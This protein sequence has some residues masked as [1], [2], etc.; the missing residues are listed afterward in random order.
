MKARSY[1]TLLLLL[2]GVTAW[3][4]AT[5]KLEQVTSVESLVAGSMYVFEQDG[6]VMNNTISSSALQTTNNYSTTGLSGTETYVWELATGTKGC[7]YIK[8]VSLSK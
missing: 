5:Y 2:L 4:Q 8:N 1:L 3:G 7:F 6:Y